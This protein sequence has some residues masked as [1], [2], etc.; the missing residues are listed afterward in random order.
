MKVDNGHIESFHFINK[1]ITKLKI[2]KTQ[3]EKKKYMEKSCMSKNMLEKI[4]E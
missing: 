3:N 1:L 2:E 4:K